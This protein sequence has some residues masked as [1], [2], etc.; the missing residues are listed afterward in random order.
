MTIKSAVRYI[1]S[2]GLTCTYSFEHKEFNVNGYF[3]DDVDD[4]I[5][6]A[7]VMANI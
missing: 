4:A 1:K 2:L 7:M 6:T 3:T 5:T